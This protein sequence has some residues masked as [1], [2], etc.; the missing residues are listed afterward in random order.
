[1][2]DFAKIAARM[3]VGFANLAESES[4]RILKHGSANKRG[5]SLLLDATLKQGHDMKTFG[6]GTAASLASRPR[7]ARFTQS[8]HSIYSAMEDSL[9]ACASPAVAPVWNTFGSALRRAP[10]LSSDLLEVGVT[11]GAAAPSA[12]TRAYVESIHAARLDDDARDGARLLAHLYVRYFADL[13]GGQACGDHILTP[14]PPDPHR[15]RTHPQKSSRRESSRI[16]T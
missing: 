6:L 8:M 15:P 14:P 12:A 5:L 3:R 16:S 13:F 1:M 9:D 7:Y 4:A 11:P 10:S 2:G